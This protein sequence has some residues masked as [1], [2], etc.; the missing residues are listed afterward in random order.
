MIMLYIHCV[1]AACQSPRSVLYVIAAIKP[2]TTA[3]GSSIIPISQMRK[4]RLRE[5]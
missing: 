4:L 3:V 5:A 1:L 2:H